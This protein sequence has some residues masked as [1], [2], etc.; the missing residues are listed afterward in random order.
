MTTFERVDEIRERLRAIDDPL[1]LLEGIF[2]Y[3]PLALQI[4]DSSGR[5][6]LTNRAFRDLF[7]AEPPPDYNVLEDDIA[8]ENG[9]LPLVERAFG[10]ETVHL[11]LM[12]YD[13]RELKKVRVEQGKRAAIEATFFPLFRRDG[14]IGHVGVVFADLTKEQRARLEAEA[15]RDLLRLI[16]AQSGDGVIVA[17]ESGKIR[18]F[19]PEAERQHGVALGDVASPKWATADG[20]FREDGA[21]LQLEETPL[22]RAIRGERVEGA[23]WKVQRPDGSVRTLSGTAV[24]LR[25]ENGAPAGAVLVSRDDTDRIAREEERAALLLNEQAARA[26]AEQANQAKDEFLAMLGHELRNPLSPVLTALSLLRMRGAAWGEELQ[27][28]HRQVSHLARLVDDLLDV[29]RIARGKIEVRKTPVEISRALQRALE[30][31]RPLIEERR[32]TL[33]VQ[34]PEEGLRVLGDETRLAQVLANL[35]TNAARYTEPGGEVRVHARREGGLAVVDVTDNGIGIAPELLPRMFDSFVQG[36]LKTAQAEGGLGLG[37][38]LAKSLVAIHGGTLRAESEG[39]GRGSTFRV[40]IPAVEDAATASVPEPQFVQRPPPV[41]RKILVVDDNRDA[42]ELLAEALRLHGHDVAVAHDGP[43]AL[44]VVRDFAP[45][46]AVLDIGLPGM[47]GHEL[48][49]E[50][51]GRIGGT[52]PLIALTGYGQDRDRAKSRA[53]GFSFHL[54]KPVNL[55]QL[56]DIVDK[57]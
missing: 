9:V 33:Y 2:T 51:R 45:D 36:S 52:V 50:L 53:A 39:A 43:S 3:S 15:E 48:A 22:Y 34:A 29:S 35:L 21:P 47:D 46:L 23:R 13:P 7:G 27:V 19:N 55:Q 32:H 30:M 44:H 8:R 25:K 10:G 40:S 17:D 5:S 37:L 24:P 14:G 56:I 54:V 1:A 11:P 41:S 12:W 38:A 42:A 28:I 16:I 6:L 57:C 26:E 4:Y 18:L 31:A 20:L 49:A